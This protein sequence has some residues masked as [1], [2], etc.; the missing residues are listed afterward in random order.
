MTPVYLVEERVNDSS[1]RG[2]GTGVAVGAVGVLLYLLIRNLGLGGG[3]ARG[4]GG[5][6]ESGRGLGPEVPTVPPMPPM[7]PM[8]P[9]PKDEQRLLFVMTQPTADDPSRPMSFRGPGARAFA[10]EEMIARVKAGGRSDVTLKTAGNVRQGSADSAL[11]LVKQAGI[12]VW[13]SGIGPA[14]NDRGQYGDYP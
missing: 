13:V 2:V 1:W 8:P 4:E 11:S 14:V 7:P 6:G 10:L 12:K 9:L 5:R 3:G